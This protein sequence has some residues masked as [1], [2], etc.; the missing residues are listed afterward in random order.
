[1]DRKAR[2]GKHDNIARLNFE[3]LVD[4]YNGGSDGQLCEEP[5]KKP[6]YCRYAGPCIFSCQVAADGSVC[7]WRSEIAWP[8]QF[9]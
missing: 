7:G 4:C 3:Y 5:G 1:M 2:A 6:V 8:G 9:E